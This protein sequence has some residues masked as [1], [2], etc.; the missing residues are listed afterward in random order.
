MNV[1]SAI[2]L[3]ALIA[4]SAAP[5]IAEDLAVVN[6]K[7]IPISLFNEMVKQAVE[8]GQADTPELHNYVKG[9]L[10]DLEVLS[11][12]ADKQGFG[13]K[14]DVAQQI[15]QTRKSIVARALVLD[16]FEKNPVTDGDIQAEY[17]KQKIAAAGE[18]EYSARHI[19]VETEEEAKAIIG[20]LN[21]G[22]TFEELAVQSKD[23]GSAANGG[24][25]E[26]ASASV[27]VKPFGDAL[28]GLKK[29]ELT[30]MPIMTQYG[31]HVI[32]LEDTRAIQFPAFEEVKPRIAENLRRPKFQA[33]LGT[34]REKAKIQ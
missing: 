14:T 21:A 19:L 17:D 26:W 33:F 4:A 28:K 11:Q 2:F 7:K 10:I 18:S 13:K 27:Y 1:K 3:I 24:L 25:L 22:V 5:V 6:G 12:E 9:Q 23:P 32:K 15:D 34:L 29:G 8:E 31:Y 16:F 20:R 30:Q